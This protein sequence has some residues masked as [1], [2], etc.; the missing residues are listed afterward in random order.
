MFAAVIPPILL[1]L[2]VHASEL[3]L[4]IPITSPALAELDENVIDP[5]AV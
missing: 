5:V 3:K 4:N 2:A 1:L